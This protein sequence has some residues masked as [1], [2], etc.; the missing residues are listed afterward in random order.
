MKRAAALL[1]LAGCAGAAP[2]SIYREGDRSAPHVLAP[3]PELAGFGA[4]VG[5]QPLPWS[6]ASLTGDFEELLFVAEWGEE[7]G[8]LLRFEGSVRVA[9]A[10]PELSAYRPDLADLVARL[11]AGAPE[12]DLSVAGGER[13]E[14]TLRSAPAAEMDRVAPDALCFFLP[15][16]GTWEEFRAAEAEGETFWDGLDRLRAVTIFL[17]EFAAPHEIRA[18]IEEEVTQ[19]LGPSNDILRLEDSIFNDDNVQGKATAFDLLML[20]ALYDPTLRAGM[21]REAARTAARRVF[22]G[23]AT[24]GETRARSR[25]DRTYADL[26]ARADAAPRPAEQAL[27]AGRAIEA[28]EGFGPADHRL[29]AAVLEAG[30]IAFFDRR[31]AEAAALLRRAEALLLARLGPEALRLADLRGDLGAILMR[32]G[33]P[34]E[35]LEALDAAIPVLAAHADEWRLAH[36]IRWRALALAETGRREAAAAA[37]AQAVAWAARVYGAGS[38][39]ERAWAEDFGALGLTE[40]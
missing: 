10:G 7:R 8:S 18:C 2:P 20:R 40:S 13:G 3:R 38:R 26:A 27:W 14:I 23:L 39:A 29:P 24:G 28:A 22:D 5:R 31:E 1:L 9:L 34:G 6:A 17:P 36:A 21:T 25:A 30:H 33:R 32:L 35:A 15:F 11:R 37:A 4:A 16:E 12:L 19:A